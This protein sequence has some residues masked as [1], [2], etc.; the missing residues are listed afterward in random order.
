MSFDLLAPHYRWMEWL[1][2]GGK[3][4]RC[5]T[6]FLDAIPPPSDVLIYG[7]GNGRFLAELLPRFPHARITV[8]DASMGMILQAQRRL[9]KVGLHVEQVRFVHAD[10]LSWTPP[11]MAFDLIVTHFF[12][13]CFREDQLRQLMPAITAAAKHEAHWLLADFQIAETGMRRL[14]SRMIVAVLYALFRLVTRLPAR[15]LTPPDPLL[16]SAGFTLRQR[17]E[18][19][20]GLLHSDWWSRRLHESLNTQLSKGGSDQ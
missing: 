4:Q 9:Q 16:E 3:L 18:H 2:A 14:R 6:A 7:E 11:A 17:Y 1:T 19:D 15:C 13:D 12:L 8:V 20:H 5:R 10:A